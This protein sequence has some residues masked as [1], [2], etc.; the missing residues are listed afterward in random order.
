MLACPGRVALQQS[1]CS[2]CD[3]RLPGPAAPEQAVMLEAALGLYTPFQSG[4]IPA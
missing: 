2:S 1:A 4:F 3:G